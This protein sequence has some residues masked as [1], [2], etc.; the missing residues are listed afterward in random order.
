MISDANPVL[1]WVSRA[2]YDRMGTEGWRR[3]GLSI[4]V[5][6]RGADKS[7]DKGLLTA[8]A[9]GEECPYLKINN[10]ICLTNSAHSWETSYETRC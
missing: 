7:G 3:C 2:V 6:N 8:Y 9:L 5:H 1:R 10:E 4:P